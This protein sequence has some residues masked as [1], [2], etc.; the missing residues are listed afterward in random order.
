MNIRTFSTLGALAALVGL[1]PAACRDRGSEADGDGGGT[2]TDGPIGDGGNAAARCE[3]DR[4]GP[5]M[6]RRLTRAEL[7]ATIRDVFP[8]IGDQ[9]SGV[10]LGP[11]PVSEHGFSNDAEALV[12]GNQTA[13]ELLTTAEDVATLVTADGMLGT[14]LPCAD[15]SPD[16]GCATE[17][18]EQRGA[19]LFRRPLS[20][21]EIARYV[22]HYDSIASRS[23]FATG[24]RWT[25]V[26]MMQSPAAVYRSELGQPDGDGYR[27]DGYEIASALAY[28]FSGLPPDDALL[29]RAAAGELD[30]PQ[31]R[32]DEAR[33]LLSTMPGILIMRRFFREW[34][35]YGQVAATV[36]SDDPGFENVRDAMEVETQS[37]IEQVVF[38]DE[39]DVRDLLTAPYTMLDPQLAAFYGYGS[40][41]GTYA[42]VDRPEN[43]GIGL[44]SQGSL[45]AANA[46]AEA[47]SPTLRGVLVYERLLCNARLTPPADVP[48]L[49]PVAEGAQT[50][51]QRYE[52]SHA[53]DPACQ[54][55][56]RLFDPIGFG[57]EHFDNVGRYRADE[58]GLPIDA[59]G[60]LIVDADTEFAF[61]GITEL[62][63]VAA[64]TPEVTDCV[65]GL[66]VGYTFGGAGGEVCVAEGARD[67][68]QAGEIGLFEYMV[69]LAGAP[70]FTQRRAP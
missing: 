6:L 42:R 53:A 25:V 66:M 60:T 38:A 2:D 51:R 55:C 41:D 57:F 7:D 43:W 18:V 37:F 30:D 9:W 52:E 22:E 68:L 11:D 48:A 67:A 13:S 62:A 59:S 8:E 45:L 23:D 56:H 34:T 4:L 3:E 1:G 70:H 29:A 40:P 54:S 63:Q 44:L 65:S 31:V 35:G 27:L 36:R 33:R 10:A 17:L 50:T 15:S 28:D 19:A 32:I 47:S 14:V 16:L 46:H 69:Q 64:D 61:D 49:T 21:E 5:P 58:Q 20:E 12:V 39:G 26:A 24:I